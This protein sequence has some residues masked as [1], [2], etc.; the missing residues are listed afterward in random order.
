[1]CCGHTHT[2]IDIAANLRAQRGW[3]GRESV[4]EIASIEIDTYQAGHDIVKEMN[5]ASPYQAKFSLAYVVVAALLTG[6]APLEVFAEQNFSEKGV[7]DPDARALL[8]RTRV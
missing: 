7:S 8:G 2:A 4:A 3:Q 5:P 6:G 1:A